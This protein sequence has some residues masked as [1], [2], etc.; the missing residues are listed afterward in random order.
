MFNILINGFQLAEQT[1]DRNEHKQLSKLA[2]YILAGYFG[3]GFWNNGNLL[4]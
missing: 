1:I 2:N 4:S 3:F